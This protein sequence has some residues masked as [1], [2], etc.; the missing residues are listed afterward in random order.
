M[1]GEKRQL[2]L[3]LTFPAV[4]SLATR[5]GALRGKDVADQIEHLIQPN[6][7]VLD[8]GCG[9]GF[10]AEE[11]SKRGHRVIGVDKRD[12]RLATGFDFRYGSAYEL[13]FRDDTFDVCLL[14]TVLHHLDF[15]DDALKEAQRV[16]RRTIVGEELK[17]PGVNWWILR[18]YDNIV[19]LSFRGSPNSNR[20]HS[21]WIKTFQRLEFQVESVIETRVFGFI[22]QAIYCLGRLR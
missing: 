19:N 5:I 14:H 6:S 21:S 20:S 13:P 17:V 9:L 4:K 22:H 8:L 1:P 10:V 18:N 11:L 15:P 3:F 7:L 2:K 12:V 16:A